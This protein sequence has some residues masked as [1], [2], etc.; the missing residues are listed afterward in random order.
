MKQNN[1]RFVSARCSREQLYF[2]FCNI[3]TETGRK[4]DMTFVLGDEMDLLSN[5]L[6]GG[7]I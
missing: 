6:V 7:T 3:A 2:L 1:A 5:V 4:R